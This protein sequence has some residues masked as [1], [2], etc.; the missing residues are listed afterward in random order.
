MQTALA[1]LLAKRDYAVA[2]AQ[3][4]LVERGASTELAAATIADF[5]TRGYLNDSRFAEKYVIFGA[6][7][8]H[9]PIRIARDLRERG[10]RQDDVAV[11]LEC[12]PDWRELCEDLRRRR[13]GAAAPVSW[14][15]KGRQ[16]RFLQYRGFS[17]D[18]MRLAL[19][20]TAE[21]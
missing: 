4:K 2:E 6:R 8:G 16:A 12:G 7:R 13:F 15:E 10:V 3:A 9:G 19:H 11:A 1:A 17:S 5:K 21:E 14:A 18:H 20:P